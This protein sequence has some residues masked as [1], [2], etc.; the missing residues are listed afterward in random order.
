MAGLP[1]YIALFERGEL[2]RRCAA[3]EKLVS[4][5][6]LCPHSCGAKRDTAAEGIC[7]SQ[8]LPMVSSAS[9]H[10]GEEAPLVGRAGSGTIFFTNCN[11]GCIFCQNY[12]ISHLGQG[13]TMS[14]RELALTMMSLQERGC[15]NINFVTPTHMVYAILKALVIAVDLGL[16]IPLVYNSGG[17]D[18][19]HT[20]KLLDGIFDIY[21]PDFKYWDEAVAHELS[22]VRDY[23]TV[24]RHALQEMYEQVGD[25]VLDE[26]GVAC[27][28]L[29]VR[30]LVLP[31]DLAGTRDIVDFVYSLSAD[32][33]VNIMD[34]YR[35]AYRADECPALKRRVSIQEFNEAVSY[36][37]M[38]GMRRLDN[39]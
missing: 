17:Y 6:T 7:R 8:L 10:F 16:H 15:H 37:K 34:Q 1:S 9:P 4:P 2:D 18:S 26:H 5:C 23:P 36:A 14:Y 11:L 33:Y 24:A 30:H 38:K 21:M 31:Q 29:L 39:W 13:R 20:L 3:V 12:D 27:R 35:P 28:G 25:L 32:T 19:L 22:G